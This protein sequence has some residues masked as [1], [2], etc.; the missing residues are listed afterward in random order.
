[1]TV[2]LAPLYNVAQSTLFNYKETDK[3]NAKRE[4]KKALSFKDQLSHLIDDKKL[5]V[6]NKENALTI[7]KHEN[8]Y[9][10]S[11]YMIDFLD[12]QD[13]FHQDVTFESIYNIYKAE[14]E[15]RSTLFELV[16]DIE[17][18][19]K[20]Q[21]ANYFSLKY[22]AIGYL[23]PLNYKHEYGKDYSD[24]IHL[25]KKF[26]E[27][28]LR[29]SNNLI[30]KH[31]NNEYNG[32]MPLWAMV[33]LMSFGM[34]S[35]FFSAMKTSDKKAVCRTGYKDITYDKLE[36]FY[37]SIAYLRNQCCHYQRFYRIKHPIKPKAYSTSNIDLG[38]VKINSTY[39]LVLA[40]LFVNPN[41]KL[42]E[43]AI[44][45][46]KS[47]EYKAHID[48]INNYGFNNN[49]QDRLYEVNGHCIKN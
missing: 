12:E 21:I 23:N 11:G 32:F 10:L 29:N 8:Y 2:V 16:N 48:F 18:Y 27:I 38:E 13:H 45:K 9:R 19:L 34:I 42:G 49:W 5:I 44:G 39:S 26:D 35:K 31:H 40:L 20:T 43:R 24:V 46:L 22:G 36:S 41:T 14:K 17:V 30:V 33:E 15:I 25:L 7:L 28:I 37:H 6:N 3:V 1:M 47:I 4:L